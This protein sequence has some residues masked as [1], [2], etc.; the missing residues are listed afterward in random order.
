MLK[1]K[2]QIALFPTGAALL[3]AT[4]LFAQQPAPAGP[5]TA[6]PPSAPAAVPAVPAI[7]PTWAQG[8]TAE[9]EAASKTISR[10]WPVCKSII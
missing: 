4:N 5:P 3:I 10:D 2:L 8:R 6:A 7:P 1:T 9:Q